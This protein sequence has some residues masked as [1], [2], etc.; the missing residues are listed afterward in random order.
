MKHYLTLMRPHQWIKNLA[1]VAGPAFGQRFDAD[2][3]T[4]TGIV[5]VVFCM[6]SSASYAINDLLDRE[7]DAVHPVKKHRPVASGAISP[8]GAVI[9]AMMLLVA[10]VGVSALTLPVRATVIIVAYFLMILAYSLALKRRMILDVILIAVGFVLRATAGAEAVEVFVSPWLLVCTFT[11]CMFL[12]FG[13]RRCEIAQFDSLEDASEHRR[14]L[15]RYTPELLNNLIS[16][17]AG[18]AIMTFLLYTMD[19]DTPSTF[20][21]QHLLYTL[22]LVVYGVF[23]YAMLVQSGEMHGPTEI[24]LHDPPFLGTIIIWGILALAIMFQGQWA[25]AGTD[26]ESVNRQDRF[27]CLMPIGAD[28]RLVPCDAEHDT[29][30][31]YTA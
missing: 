1:V 20:P 17:S 21:K 28:G 5:F 15:L 9:W 12:G 19:A 10:G 27:G 31:Y 7:A 26:A 14:T 22:P 16:V 8:A 29:P 23:R 24:I 6:V 3:L 18:I 13:K 30:G 2:S 25:D 4:M 11:L